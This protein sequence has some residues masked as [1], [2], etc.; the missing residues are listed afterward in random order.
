MRGQEISDTISIRTL[1][2]S[3][4][5]LTTVSDAEA[6]F[7]VGESYIL[8]LEKPYMGAAY[9]TIGD[10]YYVRGLKLGAFTE[11]EDGLFISQSGSNETIDS[12]EFERE[13][14]TLTENAE[15][16]ETVY[17]DTF[18]NNLHANLESGWINQEEYDR[19]LAEIEVY[20]T[21]QR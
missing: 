17:R 13:I 4:I 10:Y 21:M 16:N 1:G 8:F 18:L 19:M 20:A 2:G 9:N 5:L 14:R 6:T 12:S 3:S 11:Q 15:I 7:I